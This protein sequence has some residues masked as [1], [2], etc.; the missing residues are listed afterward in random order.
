MEKK[1]RDYV[2]VLTIYGWQKEVKVKTLVTWLR[3]T[4]YALEKKPDSISQSVYKARLM[5]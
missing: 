3:N 2:A 5:K 4:A 1:K